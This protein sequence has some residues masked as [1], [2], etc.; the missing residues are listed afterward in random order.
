MVASILQEGG[1]NPGYLIGGIP[2]NLKKSANLGSS[3]YFVIEADEYDTSFFDHQSKFLHFRPQTLIINNIEYDHADIFKDLS[4][5]QHQFHLLV[6][7]IPSDGQITYPP[8]DVNVAEVI[9]Q[10]CWSRTKTFDLDNAEITAANIIVDESEFD[11][12]SEGEIAVSY[13]HL[14][15]PT[16]YSV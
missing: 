14:T 3:S 8:S 10:G 7:K 12:C 9:S 15:L 6:R 5:I 2:S 13:T 4:Q 11:V 16:I 1:M